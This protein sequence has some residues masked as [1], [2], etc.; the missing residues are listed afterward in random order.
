MESS[1]AP[2]SQ[3]L[4]PLQLLKVLHAAFQQFMSQDLLGKTLLAAGI[5]AGLEEAF[6]RAELEGMGALAKPVAAKG[7]KK[8]QND[9][10]TEKK[11][12]KINL[13]TFFC[14][15][16][17]A[18]MKEQGFEVPEAAE[19]E[20][21]QNALTFAIKAWSNGG[22]EMHEKFKK[23]YSSLI[24][25]YNERAA[26]GEFVEDAELL[27]MTL[28]YEKKHKIK[29]V[30]N[31]AMLN[32]KRKADVPAAA[33]PSKKAKAE[34]EPKAAESSEEE[35]SDEESD[36]KPAAGKSAG[37]GAEA[38]SSAEEESSSSEEEGEE[39]EEESE[40][41]PPKPTKKADSTPKK[42]AKAPAAPASAAKKPAV[43]EEKGNAKAK[44][45]VVKEE[46]AGKGVKQEKGGAK[47]KA[48]AAE[49]DKKKKKKQ[50]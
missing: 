28:E 40:P 1:A 50:K 25:S 44:K 49:E 19:G 20:R 3:P 17:C 21:K 31:D 14:K 42:Q 41:E 8:K 18:Q 29:P 32:G 15:R 6:V 5:A 33:T 45:P 7:K 34:P 12:R 43:K 11:P 37:A 2:V 4:S 16:Y 36:G 47:G 26:K 27:A 10:D 23:D 35:S 22:E 9:D 48:A 39:S 46:K 30:F 13:Y 24:D 38:S